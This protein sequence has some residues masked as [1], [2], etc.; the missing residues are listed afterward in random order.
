MSPWV[1]WRLPGSPDEWFSKQTTCIPGSISD[2][3]ISVVGVVALPAEP[4]WDEVP[5]PELRDKTSTWESETRE[6]EGEEELNLVKAILLQKPGRKSDRRERER[7]REKESVWIREREREF[8]RQALH[9]IVGLCRTSLLPPKSKK[10]ANVVFC[11]FRL[12]SKILPK[13]PFSSLGSF[14]FVVVDVASL[15]DIDVT[16]RRHKNDVAYV[17]QKQRQNRSKKSKHW[18]NDAFM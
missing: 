9:H 11:R 7:E 16:R 6:R 12:S 15:N 4:D 14:K 13:R 17:P 3:W 8:S 2:L 18:L 10:V 1:M 5:T